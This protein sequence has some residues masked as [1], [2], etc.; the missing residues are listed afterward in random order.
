METL[1]L[2]VDRYQSLR[3]GSY[4]LVPVALRNKKEVVNVKNKDDHCLRW[5]LRA[6][7]FPVA[8]DP[9]RP[10]KYPTEDWLNLE[11]IAAPTPV[12]QI[13]KV[14]WQNNLAIN[15]FGWDKGVI[16]HCISS[17]DKNMPRIN[18]LLIK[19]TGK[20]HYTWV[21]DLNRLL[22]DQSK[23]VHHKYF[24]KYCFHGYT[25]E[26]LLEAHREECRWIG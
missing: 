6:A 1:W 21:K 17:Q 15:V 20:F 22:F 19:K 18:L 3:G 10:T 25:R 7:L 24:C 13:Q 5:A 12:S 9:Q 14:E 26:D 2:D 4:I 16:V 23:H 11:G 8:K